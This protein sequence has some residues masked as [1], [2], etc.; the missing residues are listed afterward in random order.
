MP[1][2]DEYHLCWRDVC[3]YVWGRSDIRIEI[4][5]V[6]ERNRHT[7]FR[8]LNYQMEEFILRKYDVADGTSAIE[9]ILSRWVEYPA[10]LGRTNCR[11]L[12][13]GFIPLIRGTLKINISL[14]QGI[15]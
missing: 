15:S 5:I 2:S 9:F 14:G 8:A 6:N 13:R 4:P 10:L 11:G 12:P 1:F 7:Y 3:G